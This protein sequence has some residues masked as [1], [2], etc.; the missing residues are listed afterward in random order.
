MGKLERCSSWFKTE[1]EVQLYIYRLGVL[2][3]MSKYRQITFRWEQGGLSLNRTK[4]IPCLQKGTGLPCSRSSI[5]QI[6][7]LQNSVEGAWQTARHLTFGARIFPNI[8][9]LLILDFYLFFSFYLFSF[10]FIQYLFSFNFQLFY[11]VLLFSV[12]HQQES[13]IGIHICPPS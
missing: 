13:A 3:L 5:G 6:G 11:R 8:K 12:K 10:Y 9:Y 4:G 2:K 1:S 7:E